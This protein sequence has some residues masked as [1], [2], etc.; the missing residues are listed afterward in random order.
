MF[1]EFAPEPA[2][3][4][5][6]VAV[7]RQPPGGPCAEFMK[8]GLQPLR[9]FIAGS[10]GEDDFVPLEVMIRAGCNV[11]PGSFDERGLGFGPG[12]ALA[13]QKRAKGGLADDVVERAP[14]RVIKGGPFGALFE[15]EQ[16]EE[17]LKIECQG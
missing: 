5:V 13:G 12:A 2:Y 15:G 17:G 14:D 6:G 10:R 11:R 8:G 4:C 7:G 16:V 3:A 1:Q 9:E